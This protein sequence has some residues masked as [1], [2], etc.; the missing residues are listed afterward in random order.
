MRAFMLKASLISIVLIILLGLSGMGI[1][2]AAPF[3]PGQFDPTADFLLDNKTL[4]AVRAADLAERAKLVDSLLAKVAAMNDVAIQYRAAI[5][6]EW[7]KILMELPYTY[8]GL[9]IRNL[10]R[11]LGKPFPRWYD[12]IYS[13]QSKHVHA[14]DP[15]HHVRI[16]EDEILRPQWHSK[17]NSVRQA[18]MTA[19][20]MFYATIGI[21]NRHVRFGIVMNTALDSFHQEHRRLLGR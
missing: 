11:N 7:E 14:A 13:D 1:T 3:K 16:G 9:S 21:L 10:A 17:A 5:G 4:N 19:I 15:L 20:A 2:T 18:L 6:P 12:E 8:C